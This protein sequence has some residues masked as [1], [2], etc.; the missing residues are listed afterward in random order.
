MLDRSNLQNKQQSTWK[1][2]VIKGSS[3]VVKQLL[4]L[5]N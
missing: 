5:T 1:L 2:N 4:Q 3:T